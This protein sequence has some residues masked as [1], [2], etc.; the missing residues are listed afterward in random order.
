WA[1]D[2]RDP[3]DHLGGHLRDGG[4]ALGGQAAFCRAGA[5]GA[6]QIERFPGEPF[7]P[8]LRYLIGRSSCDPPKVFSPKWKSIYRVDRATISPYVRRSMGGFSRGCVPII[9]LAW[10]IRLPKRMR[11][12]NNGA[13]CL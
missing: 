6:S 2:V 1:S 13:A 11:H 9:P 12:S 7:R 8:L 4:S 10:Q 5:P 3:A